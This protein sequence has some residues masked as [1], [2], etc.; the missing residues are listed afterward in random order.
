[1][2]VTHLL[3]LALACVV[4]VE[5]LTV[6]LTRVPRT[7]AQKAAYFERIRSGEAARAVAAKYHHYVRAKY[8]THAAALAGPPA[9]PFKNYD[10]VC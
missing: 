7:P 6:P 9:D 4:V 3:I 2:K 1:M 5:S 10:D 8:P